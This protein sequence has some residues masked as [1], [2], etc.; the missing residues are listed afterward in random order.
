MDEMEQTLFE[1]AWVEMMNNFHGKL[2]NNS[3]GKSLEDAL[4][5]EDRQRLQAMERVPLEFQEI[6]D[7]GVATI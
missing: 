3:Q 1:T 7:P 4:Y 5:M 6:T 2:M